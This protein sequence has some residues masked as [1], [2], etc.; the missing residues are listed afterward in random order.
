MTRLPW[1]PRHS[2]D[3]LAESYKL[4]MAERGLYWTLADLCWASGCRLA[5]D[6]RDLRRMSGCQPNHW[7]R[8]W[9]RVRPYFKLVT[10]PDGSRWWEHPRLNL[11]LSGVE[12]RADQSRSN[13]RKGGRPKGVQERL[14][15][16]E[17]QAKRPFRRDSIQ[18]GIH[19]EGIPDS[20]AKSLKN[21]DRVNPS[22]FQN[23]TQEKAIQI[24][25]TDISP[26]GLRPSPQKGGAEGLS[27]DKSARAK[28]LPAGWIPKL[29]HYDL[30]QAKGF[31]STFVDELSAI[32]RDHAAA[33]TRLRKH[34]WDAEFSSRLRTAL[35]NKTGRKPATAEE[36]PISQYARA[37][38]AHNRG[39]EQ[40]HDEQRPEEPEILPPDRWLPDGPDGGDAGMAGD[41]GAAPKQA[42]SPR[43]HVH[44]GGKGR[45]NG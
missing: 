6:E 9:P 22:G 35:M 44:R 30:A 20:V 40:A 43:F 37:L 5:D 32:M 4:T 34:D 16:D 2:Q 14:P 31:D 7:K 11:L 42:G 26:A 3:W 8:L 28:S 15:L 24:L 10:D 27:P 12:A 25:D 23:K 45:A 36:S 21:K 38:E 29:Q 13:G 33:N 18:N 19:S 17:D 1:F 39:E 41:G